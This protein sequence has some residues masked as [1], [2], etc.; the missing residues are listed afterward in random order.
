MLVRAGGVVHADPAPGG[1]R[2][3]RAA[4]ERVGLGA[5]RVLRR[6]RPVP[7]H[8]ARGRRHRR[9]PR[10]RAA[11]PL[12]PAR[13]RRTRHAASAPPRILSDTCIL[14]H[15]D[16]QIMCRVQVIVLFPSALLV[17]SS[18][19]PNFLLP[20]LRQAH[21]PSKLTYLNRASASRHVFTWRSH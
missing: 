17:S 4:A 13:A 1:V 12:A 11:R 5:R 7:D 21:L 8:D 18:A 15:L 9:Q 16:T 3:A 19:S 14:A 6:A 10:L 20:I 2:R